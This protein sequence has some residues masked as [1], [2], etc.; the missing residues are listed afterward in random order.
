MKV[1]DP[2]GQT[3]RVTRRWVP[4]R[5]RIKGDGDWAPDGGTLEFGDDPV[6]LAVAA[7]LLVPFVV[8]ALLVSVELLLIL[9][10]LPVALIGR[11]A[12]GRHWTVELR[13]GWK[14]YW[15]ESVG[16]WQASGTRIHEVADGVRRGILPSQTLNR[17]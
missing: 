4:W 16:D 12:F 15:E 6:S 2:S 11:V 5:R 10:V 13:R 8:L 17:S 1:Q 9:L 3:W 7:I 14:P